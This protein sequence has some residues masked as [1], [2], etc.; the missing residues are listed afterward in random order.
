MPKNPNF[1]NKSNDYQ[2]P[3]IKYKPY[4]DY[5]I[6]LIK[7]KTQKEIVFGDVTWRDNIETLGME[8]GF[9]TPRN[10]DDRHMKRYD[11]A[12]VG[13]GILFKNKDV[14]L[15]RGIITTIDFARYSK[16]ITAHDYA[17]Y[18]NKSKTLIQFN[19]MSGSAAIKK[20][21]SANNVPV[22][23]IDNMN[24]KITE[25]Y[26]NQSVSDIIKDIL[27]KQEDH[28]GGKYR[29]EMRGG[30]LYVFKA[31]TL[32][33]KPTFKPAKNISAFDP[34]K[35]PGDISKTRTMEG[36]LTKV[37]V[38]L[39]EEKKTKTLATEVDN[40]NL[41]KY[42]LFQEVVSVSKEESKNAKKIAKQKLDDHKGIQETISVTMFGDDKV[43]SGRTI[44]FSNETFGLKGD[45]LIT[46]CEHEYKNNQ[47]NMKL[48]I[49]KV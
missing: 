10:I 18:L 35:L 3:V 17:Y 31:T 45:Y 24:V 15:F 16:K 14:E 12:E 1:L 46:D 9:D 38:T 6:F 37:L 43:R 42:G 48:E 49:K 23:K 34:T 33:I 27:S 21:C 4:K 32:K 5:K 26:N 13:D 19:K 22:G 2:L 44:V 40:E 29:M 8:I 47:R 39:E 41:K 11:I 7:G 28:D 36:M 20:L 25:I 30:K